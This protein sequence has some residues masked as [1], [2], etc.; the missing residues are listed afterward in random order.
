M[1]V[2]KHIWTKVSVAGLVGAI[3]LETGNSIIYSLAFSN[4]NSH[5]NSSKQNRAFK[6][7]TVQLRYY[8]KNSLLK[9]YQ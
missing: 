2:D 3:V 4:K 6:L 5:N 9:K 1:F 8:T 7:K